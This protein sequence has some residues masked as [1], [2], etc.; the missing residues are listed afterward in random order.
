MDTEV[1]HIDFI[2]YS[3]GSRI[4]SRGRKPAR[5]APTYDLAKIWNEKLD[6][7]RGGG[8]GGVGASKILLNLY[9]KELTF[10]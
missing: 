5:G 3:G 8:G 1:A 9:V 6:Q 7:G 2:L 4:S 10:G